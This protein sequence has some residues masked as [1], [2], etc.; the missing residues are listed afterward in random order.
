M[1]N[2]S[3]KA[4]SAQTSNTDKIFKAEVSEPRM[5]TCLQGRRM[6]GMHS[7]TVTE[8]KKYEHLIHIARKKNALT[9]QAKK[10]IGKVLQT[11]MAMEEDDQ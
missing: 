2:E 7:S 6:K 8:T 3:V 10:S 5:M 9:G 11:D 1:I 4:L